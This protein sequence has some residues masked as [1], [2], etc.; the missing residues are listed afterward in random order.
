MNMLLA[1]AIMDFC[2]PRNI[3]PDTLAYMRFENFAKKLS[4]ESLKLLID[5]LAKKPLN[6][7]DNISAMIWMRENIK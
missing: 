6:R 4:D 5:E 2:S 3:T 1:Q 7:L